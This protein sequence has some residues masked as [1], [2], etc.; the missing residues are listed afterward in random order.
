[1][2]PDALGTRM[3]RY[4][5]AAKPLLVPRTPV[6]IRIDGRAF[7]TFTKGCA[8]P[9]D[10]DLHACMWAAA[11]AV[12]ADVAG[13]KLAYVQ[14]DEISLLVTDYEALNTQPHFDYEVAK[15]C[16]TTAATASVAFLV[17]CA[18][19]FPDRWARMLA[20]GKGL[21]TFDSRAYNVPREDVANYFIWRQKDAE[22]NSLTMYAQAYY[23]HKELQGQ[24]RS[25]KHELLYQKG[26]N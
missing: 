6:I 2:K 13:C 10:P 5:A 17:E 19:R 26:V 14:S 4:E 16:S 8:R 9:Y 15:L 25:A 20:T 1:M 11:K 24:G 18:R 21:P 23:S 3:K 12:C 7:H 22:R